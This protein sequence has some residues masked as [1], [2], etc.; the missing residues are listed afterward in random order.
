MQTLKVLD[1]KIAE[2]ERLLEYLN[3]QRRE[4]INR[5]NLNKVRNEQ[6]NERS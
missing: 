5:L 6:V 4:E 1:E 2:C 3:E